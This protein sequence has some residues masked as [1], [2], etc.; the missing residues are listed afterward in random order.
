MH[1]P[2]T[3]DEEFAAT[4]H[5]LGAFRNLHMSSFAERGDALTLYDDR[6]VWLHRAPGCVYDVDVGEDQSAFGGRCGESS[7]DGEDRKK[8]SSR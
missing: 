7:C 8:E 2:E 4:F 6:H 1:I 5:D 3:G